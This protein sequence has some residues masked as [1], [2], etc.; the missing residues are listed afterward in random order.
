MP[1]SLDVYAAVTVCVLI[2]AGI[3]A[4]AGVPVLASF[5]VLLAGLGVLSGLRTLAIYFHPG[6]RQVNAHDAAA[7]GYCLLGALAARGL[8]VLGLGL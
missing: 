6:A 3:R 7:L 4:L 5:S 1:L 2:F 8:M